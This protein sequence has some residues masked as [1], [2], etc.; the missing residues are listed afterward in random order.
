MA[1]FFKQ[2]ANR[3]M[4]ARLQGAGVQTTRAEARPRRR[5]GRWREDVRADGNAAELTR[6]EATELIVAA[7][8]KVTGSV[9][10][11][12]DYVVAGD[13]PGSKLAKA[14]TLGIADSRRSRPPPP[15]EAMTSAV[16]VVPADVLTPIGAYRAL[17]QPQASCL[18]ESVESGGRIS[19]YS[20]IGLDYRA[21]QDFESAPDLYD[22]VRAF[23]A[24]HRAESEGTNLGGALLAFSYDSA[25][26]DARLARREPSAPRD[27]RGLRR[28]SRDVADLR[29]LHRS[30]HDCGA[31]ATTR[32]VR[33]PHRRLRRTAARREA[34]DARTRCAPRCDERIDRS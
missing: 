26:C 5:A 4:I 16:R 31:A 2:P 7:G 22:R 29:P 1:L 27:A 17:A 19:R 3:A 6:D 25:R 34:R 32:A 20:F 18:L 15:V 12:T 10:K 9:S 13:E 21:A 28:D 8:G 23:V 30:P 33:A 24:K 11:K 14:E